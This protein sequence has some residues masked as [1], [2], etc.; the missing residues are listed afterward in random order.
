MQRNDARHQCLSLQEIKAFLG[1]EISEQ[2]KANFTL[3]FSTCELCKEVKDSFA[4]VN[5]LSI[6]EDVTALKEE[7]FTTINRRS[8]T[9]RRRFIARIA[10]GVLLPI[11]GLSTLF[12]WN[13]TANDRLYKAHFQSYPIL[14][15]VTR[16]DET[17]GAGIES[18]DNISLPKSLEAALTAYKAKNYK[19][20]I[21]HF[22]TYLSTQSQNTKAVFL[23]SLANLEVDNIDVAI[24]NLQE[25]R[26]RN[27]DQELYEDATWYLALA[28]TKKKQNKV[29]IE[30]LTE[31]IEQKS[32][33]YSKKAK[34][35]S[36]QL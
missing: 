36:S 33:F 16:G 31:L 18:Y 5:Q 6:E 1:N 3:H 2:E 25:V 8:L 26:K 12:Y 20:S 13:S 29:A 28:Q 4:T 24:P 27:D 32:S 15:D 10:A 34:A 19:A 21:P 35:L 23:Y 9:T 7:V 30:L 14:G 11:M 17:R 22:K